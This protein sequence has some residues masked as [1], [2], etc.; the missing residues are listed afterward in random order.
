MK[1]NRISYRFYNR[2]FAI[3]TVKKKQFMAKVEF[4]RLSG[5]TRL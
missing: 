3:L 4:K 2:D 5:A 1:V